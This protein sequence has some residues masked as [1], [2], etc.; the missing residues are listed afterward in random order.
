[1]SACS[2]AL[3]EAASFPR[4]VSQRLCVL[5]RGLQFPPWIRCPNVPP[6]SSGRGAH[7][8]F[9]CVA[10]SPNTPVS[11]ESDPSEPALGELASF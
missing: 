6:A 5:P 9:L 2:E 7:C 8:W 10:D 1:M 11:E 4:P 3:E